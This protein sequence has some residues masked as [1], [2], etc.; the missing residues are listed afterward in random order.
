MK[1]RI[2]TCKSKMLNNKNK[3]LTKSVTNSNHSST[4]SVKIN[5]VRRKISILEQVSNEIKEEIEQTT[6][7]VQDLAAKQNENQAAIEK[8]LGKMTIIQAEDE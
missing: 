6:K 1:V 3:W 7:L 5:K 8:N 2:S 4:Q